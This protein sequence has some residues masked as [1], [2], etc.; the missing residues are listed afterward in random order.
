MF[1]EVLTSMVLEP[2][3][4]NQGLANRESQIAAL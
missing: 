2:D 3:R 4:E 1:G